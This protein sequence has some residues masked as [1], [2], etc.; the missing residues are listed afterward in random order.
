[1]LGFALLAF[2]VLGWVVLFPIWLGF[3]FGG[4]RRRVEALEAELREQNA[5]RVPIKYQ[6]T[7]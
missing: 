3:K 7:A 2:A 6:L 5:N 1:M 4:L